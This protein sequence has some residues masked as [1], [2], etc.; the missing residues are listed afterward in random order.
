MKIEIRYFAALKEQ[1]G[2]A[3]E[4]IETNAVTIADLYAEVQLKHGFI[5]SIPQLKAAIGEEMAPWHTLLK[6][7]DCVAFLPP[8]SGG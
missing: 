2:V 8:V 6:D 7:N 5:L 4:K 3:R 1:S